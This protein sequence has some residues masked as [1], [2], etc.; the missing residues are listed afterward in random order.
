[1]EQTL[2]LQ[3]SFGQ[4][5]R[6]RLAFEPDGPE[7]EDALFTHR[8][9]R[10]EGR[11]SLL[12]VA[13]SPAGAR[14]LRR[15]AEVFDRVGGRH[16][17]FGALLGFRT[18][19][20]P[21]CLLVT[22]RGLPIARLDPAPRLDAVQLARAARDLFGALAALE[23]HGFA[24]R[25]VSPESVFW[26]GRRLEIQELGHVQ[27]L[28]PGAALAGSALATPTGLPASEMPDVQAA[29]RVIHRLATGRHHGGPPD[30]L[31][32][33]LAR[34]DPALA[35]VLAPAL[36]A[37]PGPLVPP[38]AIAAQLVETAPRHAP[39]RTAPEAQPVQPAPAR[40]PAAPG[41]RDHAFRT[42][43]RE[44]R[45]QQREFRRRTTERTPSRRPRAAVDAFSP[46]TAAPRP[47]TPTGDGASPALFV[48]AGAIVLVLIVVVV[49]MVR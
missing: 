16:A 34:I 40:R 44:L 45:R 49:L 15:E 12:K 5:G 24:H 48:F 35:A 6:V 19:E 36:H 39:A 41:D 9:G 3:K 14:V 4:P 22:R 38:A 43:F 37:G 27:P 10:T 17:C 23:E 26:D 2:V 47:A 33:D 31:L 20:D 11:P 25:A 46:P 7:Y 32:A 42:E 21:V 8:H 1:M 18:A 28:G 13:V 30:A 29:A